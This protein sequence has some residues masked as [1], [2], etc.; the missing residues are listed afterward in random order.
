MKKELYAIVI[1]DISHEAVGER[2]FCYEKEVMPTPAR[3]IMDMAKKNGLFFE[4]SEEARIF[5]DEVIGFAK[6]LYEE[7]KKKED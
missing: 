4:S 7:R 2:H 6:R 5:R 3:W 1:G